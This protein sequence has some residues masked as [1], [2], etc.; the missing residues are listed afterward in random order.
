MGLSMQ[1]Q[2]H[3]ERLTLFFLAN[4][5]GTASEDTPITIYIYIHTEYM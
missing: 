3:T 5:F 2:R 4:G 1:L